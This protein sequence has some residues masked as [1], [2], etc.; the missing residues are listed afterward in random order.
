MVPVLS[1]RLDVLLSFQEE[2]QNFACRREELRLTSTFRACNLQGAL[3]LL[4]EVEQKDEA[5]PLPP[6]AAAKRL[7][8]HMTPAV[9]SKEEQRPPWRPF[10]IFGHLLLFSFRPRL[11]VD[12]SGHRLAVC[13]EARFPAPRTAPSL[14][15]GPSP[16]QPTPQECVHCRRGQVRLANTPML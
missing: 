9:C 1:E 13:H 11:P 3:D 6:C 15:P 16:P 5:P 4:Q 8:P 2:L 12:A 7:L 10:S 14:Q